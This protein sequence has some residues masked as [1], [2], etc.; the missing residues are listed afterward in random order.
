VALLKPLPEPKTDECPASSVAMILYAFESNKR[1]RA[2][3][4]P[5]K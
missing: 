5:W 4:R 2:A 1:S 3:T